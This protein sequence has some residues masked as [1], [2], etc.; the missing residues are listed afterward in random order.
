MVESKP[1]MVNLRLD[2][3]SVIPVPKEAAIKS[4]LIN[5][6]IEEAKIHGF[7]IGIAINPETPTSVLNDHL[8]EIDSVLFMGVN[9]GASGRPFHPERGIIQG[10]PLSPFY[11][12]LG[13]QSS[14][15]L[16]FRNKAIHTL[17]TF[18]ES[19]SGSCT[20]LGICSK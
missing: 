15:L 2:D 11:L 8:Y 9:P 17:R 7:E 1:E 16:Y 10:D 6:A 18:T 14:N 3:G 4:L 5:A 13:K 19:G 20:P 12:F